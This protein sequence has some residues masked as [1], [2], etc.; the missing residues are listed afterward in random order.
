M[1]KFHQVVPFFDAQR[2]IEKTRFGVSRLQRLRP[3]GGPVATRSRSCPHG[4]AFE[5]SGDEYLYE[6]TGIVPSTVGRPLGATIALRSHSPGAL[7]AR[8]AD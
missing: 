6:A 8:P 1:L 2:R 4:E 5:G 7:Y 3:S